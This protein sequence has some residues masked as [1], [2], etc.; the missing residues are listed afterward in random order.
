MPLYWAEILNAL[1]AQGVHTEVVVAKVNPLINRDQPPPGRRGVL[2]SLAFIRA[3]LGS[4]TSTFVCV[5]YSVATA[6]TLVVA[7][8]RRTRALIFQE[9]RGR[10]GLELARWERGYRRLLAALAHGVVANTD[11]AYAELTKVL[12]VSPQKVFRATL[13]VPPERHALSR[14]GG[15]PS[16]LRRPL[17]LFVGQ[18]ARRKNVDGLI[19]AS[20][21]LR[22]RGRDFE[23]WIVGDGP[24]R[25]ALERQASELVDE[26]VVRFLGS[27]QSSEV[28]GFYDAAD[29]FVMP[30]LRDYRSV[31]VL[32]AL[33]FGTP[34]IDSVRDGNAGDFVR[35]ESTGIIFDPADP[36]ALAEA[37][38]WAIVEPDR[39]SEMGKSA[40]ALLEEHT[41]DAAAS[42][43]R[44]VIRAVAEAEGN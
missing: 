34:V 8:V 21:E 7:R 11:A 43:L 19:S 35:H 25:A 1:Q 6:I 33:R 27:C 16:P 9:H 10:E 24:E 18:L 14:S 40:A 39:F 42:R 44:D 37:M 23:V 20:T 3:L 22:A 31:A 28:G 30:S 2:P 36:N 17:F 41:P 15:V 38:E 26:S 32:E 5:E 12:R 29:V 13:L 4:S